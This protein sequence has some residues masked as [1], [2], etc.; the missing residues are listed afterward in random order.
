[1]SESDLR[2]MRAAIEVAQRARDKGNHPF[3]ALLVD[4]E[5]NVLLEAENTVVS[6]RDSTGHA[7]TN[8]MRQATRRFDRDFLAE[9][10][11]YTSTEPCPM[12]AGAIFWGNVRRVVYG[13]S[14]ERLY[15]MA[16]DSVEVLYL[17]CREVFGRGRKP[18]TVVG[19]VL[20]EEAKRVHEGFWG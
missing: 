13:L 20:E 9:C 6:D 2:F 10:T 8:L 17:P 3:G 11:I 18:V 19:P 5:G 7:E 4:K 15:E 12:C 14:E 1:M 16:G